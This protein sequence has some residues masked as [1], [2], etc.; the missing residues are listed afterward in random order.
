MSEN[1]INRS[2]IRGNGQEAPRQTAVALL[3]RNP[4]RWI[5]AQICAMLNRHNQAQ[6]D[7]INWGRAMQDEWLEHNLMPKT[8]SI[9]REYRPEAGNVFE[10]EPCSEPVDQER[11]DR[12]EA[13]VVQIGQKDFGAHQAL[14]M[15]YC[16]H[17]NLEEIA[18]KNHWSIPH[19]RQKRADG[20]RLYAQLANVR[21]LAAA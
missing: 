18:R 19:A 5:M 13:I 21:H 8:A 15:R 17:Y 1:Y 14:V 4:S 3:G 16:H 12:T 11:A 20:E 9:F 10:P 7:L 6:A 2:I